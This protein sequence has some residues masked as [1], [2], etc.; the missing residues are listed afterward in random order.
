[1]PVED[2]GG[3]SQRFLAILDDELRPITYGTVQCDME[4]AKVAP[5][6]SS[7]HAYLRQLNCPGT[8]ATGMGLLGVR[9]KLTT[10]LKIRLPLHQRPP[11][12]TAWLGCP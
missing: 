4:K 9:P 1:M 10:A 6:P 5:R 11:I 7:A 12:Y 3:Q 8:L 2:W